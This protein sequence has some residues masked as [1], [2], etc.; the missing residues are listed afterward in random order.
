MARRCS[1][2]GEFG[3]DAAVVGVDGD[4]RGDDVGE[5]RRAALD[6]GGGGL[7]AGGFDAEDQADP[8]F[9]ALFTISVVSADAGGMTMDS[10][11]WRFAT[12]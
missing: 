7:V 10:G 1:R 9:G 11:D 4:L 6:D 8:V 5:R 12:H 3:D 2:R